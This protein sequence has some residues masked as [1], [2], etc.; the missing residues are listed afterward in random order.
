M[1]FLLGFVY[2]TSGISMPNVYLLFFPI[3]IEEGRMEMNECPFSAMEV[4][5]RN[6]EDYYGNLLFRW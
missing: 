2:V 5:S 6:L 3:T 4:L 1:R